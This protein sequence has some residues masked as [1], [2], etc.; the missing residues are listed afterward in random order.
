MEIGIVGKTNTGK[1]SF[2]KAATLIDVEIGNRT[3]VTIKPNQ[4]VGFVTV[5]CPCKELGV[6]CN[7]NNS[8]CVNGIRFVPVKLLDVAGL[9]P[10]AH[11]GRGLGNKFL[12]D[13]TRAD[14]LI[15][16]VDISGT[17]DA[18]G[19]PTSGYDPSNDIKFLEEEIDL[20]FESVIKRN[21]EKI[22]DEKKAATVLSGLGI[23]ERHILEAL[24]KT[25]VEPSKLSRELRK[26][27]LP[28][29]VAANKI[30][31][32]G[33]D[34]NLDDA[35][36]N[37]SDLTIIP[38]SAESE[39]ALKQAS[40]SGV[41][42]YITGSDNFKVK[43]KVNEKQEKALEFVKKSVLEKYG[44]TGVQEC[45]NK[46]VFDFLEYIVVYPVENENKLSDKK[47]NVLPDAHLMPKG[48][49][50]IDLAHKVHED[51]GKNFIGAID[52]RTKKRIGADHELKNGDII[53]IQ[54][55]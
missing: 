22:K 52:A 7:P 37:F 44:S 3:F 23:K 47:G 29:V 4:G 46:S 40:K 12:S 43:G 36:N 26:L 34:K 14:V 33:S 55:R 6:K 8:N 18:E 32:A 39:I 25:G 50:V 35:K 38:C 1:S 48:S 16:V 20:W 11:E 51:I 17:T 41:I 15:Y 10:G 27:S 49:T 28:I 53:S 2:F 13:L 31:V 19:Q 21:L 9:V 54:S 24:E 30:D 5:S 45:L 42:E